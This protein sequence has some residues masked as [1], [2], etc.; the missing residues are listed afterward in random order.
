MRFSLID[1][2]TAIEP[3]QSITALK[4][5]SLAEEYLADHF[6][7]FAVMPGVMMLET[8]V[9]AGGWLIRVTEDFEHSSILLKQ[10]R[11]VKFNSFV[12]PG[13][14]L[15]VTATIHKKGESDYTL[16]AAGKV[17]GKPTVSARI[18]LDRFNLADRSPDLA[19]SDERITKHMREIFGQIWTEK[20]N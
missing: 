10:A 2:I 7:G 9:Q 13:Q 4:N 14:T 6:P 1:R 19:K 5:L 17:D 15:E 8:L 12:T 18:T 20:T 3:G 16:K 11:A